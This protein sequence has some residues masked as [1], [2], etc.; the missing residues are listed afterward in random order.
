MSGSV[1]QVGSPRVSSIVYRKAQ[2]LLAAGAV[3]ELNLVEAWWNRN[4]AIGAWNYTIPPD[5]SPATVDWERFLGPAPHRPFEP[6]RLFRWRNFD[7]YGTGVA[8][9]LFV[10]LFS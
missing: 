10:H 9:D 4:T 8:G 2:E 1:C 7:D 6:I 3:G 5:A